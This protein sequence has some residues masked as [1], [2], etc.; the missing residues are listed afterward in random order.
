MII[1]LVILSC[2]KQT[3]KLLFDVK[4]FNSLSNFKT[5]NDTLKMEFN[6]DNA[7]KN[8][9]SLPNQ[10]KEF[11]EISFQVPLTLDINTAPPIAL[12]PRVS[13]AETIQ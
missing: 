9:I 10:E 7:I 4:E 13:S 11:F 12:P 3:S 8:G 2:N 6:L 1:S 5:Q